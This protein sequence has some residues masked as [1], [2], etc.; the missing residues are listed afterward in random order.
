MDR[1]EKAYE[2]D[3]QVYHGKEISDEDREFVASVLKEIFE[4]DDDLFGIRMWAMYA[5]KDY[6]V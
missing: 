3:S 6:N 1:V 5:A 4:S 2:L